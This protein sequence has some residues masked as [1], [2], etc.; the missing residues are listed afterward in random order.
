MTAIRKYEALFYLWLIAQIN[1]YETIYHCSS[2][3]RGKKCLQAIE[4]IEQGQLSNT[5]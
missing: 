4:P 3:Q 5:I 1:H 2:L